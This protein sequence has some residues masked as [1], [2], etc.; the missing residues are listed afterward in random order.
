VVPVELTSFTANV[1]DN[2]VILNWTTATKINN[3][4]FEID[5]SSVINQQKAGKKLIL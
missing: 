4:E 2:K 1:E 5:K 3:F